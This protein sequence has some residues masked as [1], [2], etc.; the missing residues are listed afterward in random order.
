MTGILDA[1]KVGSGIVAGIVAMLTYNWVIHD[2]MVRASARSEYVALAE[3]TAAVAKRDEL[4][5]QVNAG[6]LVIESY[7][8]QLRNARAADAAK[9]AQIETEIAEYEVR[10][11]D[12]DRRCDLDD[13]DIRWLRQ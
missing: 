12:A 9:T 13:N 5:R 3:H 8:V 4:Q 11:K 6:N 1:L 10:I 2:P 7:Q